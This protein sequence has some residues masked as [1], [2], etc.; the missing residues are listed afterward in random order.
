M[1]RILKIVGLAIPVVLYVW[2][3][4]VGSLGRVR[5]A[6]RARRFGASRSSH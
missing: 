3:A 4:A 6:K 1:G 5:A 2:V